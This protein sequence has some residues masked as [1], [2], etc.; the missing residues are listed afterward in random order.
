MGNPF[1]TPRST[2]AL[3]NAIRDKNKTRTRI[4]HLASLVF[5]LWGEGGGGR[6]GKEG[7]ISAALWSTGSFSEQRLVIEPKGEGEGGEG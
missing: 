4:L 2:S 1:L 3:V 7:S 6:G 5:F